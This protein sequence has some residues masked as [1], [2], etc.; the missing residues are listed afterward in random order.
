MIH[1]FTNVRLASTQIGRSVGRSGFILRCHTGY[2]RV[3][4]GSASS[5]LQGPLDEAALNALILQPP[6]NSD[7]RRVLIQVISPQSGPKV[8]ATIGFGWEEM[9]CYVAKMHGNRE[10]GQEMKGPALDPLNPQS[11]YALALLRLFEQVLED[12]AFVERLR[13]HYQ[14]V[15][16]TIRQRP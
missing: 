4:S 11:E 15:Q 13:R 14:L 7:C 10:H 12:D 8:V 5:K 3:L 16:D 2:W 9:D 1:C 6:L